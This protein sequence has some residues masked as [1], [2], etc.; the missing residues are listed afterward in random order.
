[1]DEFQRF[2]HHPAIA[3]YLRDGERLSFGARAI[4]K[5][6]LRSLPKQQ[7]LGGLLIGCD[8]GT[9]NMGKIKGTH[10]AMKSG[11]LSAEAVYQQLA[12]G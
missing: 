1:F 3:K 5:G 10:T 8:A 2:K 9:L 11:M 4:A 12:K 7:F 6:G